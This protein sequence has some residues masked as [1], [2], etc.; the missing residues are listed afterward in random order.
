MRFIVWLLLSGFLAMVTVLGVKGEIP[1]WVTVA[2]WWFILIS[3]LRCAIDWNV[4]LYVA[5]QGRSV[6]WVLEYAL[7]FGLIWTL[8]NN[9]WV[10]TSL[11]VVLNMILEEL[12]F[13]TDPTAY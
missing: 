5:E 13:S 8:F 3:T 6:P 9:G 12:I 7:G 4:R 10:F 2:M 11:V 1:Q